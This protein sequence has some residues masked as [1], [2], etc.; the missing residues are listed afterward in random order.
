[1]NKEGELASRCMETSK[2]YRIV[3]KEMHKNK[4]KNKGMKGGY[5]KVNFD[6]S[7]SIGND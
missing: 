3:L 2:C 5:I 1:V 4:D 6:G 7:T